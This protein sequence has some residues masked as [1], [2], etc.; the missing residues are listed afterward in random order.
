MGVSSE[1]SWRVMTDIT[2]AAVA[3]FAGCPDDR[4]RFLLE[5]LTTHLHAFATEVGLKLD[6]WEAGIRLLTETGRITDEHRQEFILWSDTLGLSMLVDA[7]A[8]PSIIYE[9][10]ATY[11]F[12]PPFP[13]LATHLLEEPR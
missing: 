11:A 3:S 1:T 8:N 9:A 7:L 6:E 13:S 4:L 12:H 5:R 10:L 2:A